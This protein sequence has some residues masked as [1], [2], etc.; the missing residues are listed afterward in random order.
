M[1]GNFVRDVA[2]KVKVYNVTA[3]GTY[4]LSVPA[5][6]LGHAYDDIMDRRRR[7]FA[8][9]IQH[10]GTAGIDGS[11]TSV[12]VAALPGFP[13]SMIQLSVLDNTWIAV[14][15][16]EISPVGSSQVQFSLPK[17]LVVL[18]GS[19][20]VRLS[21]PIP[22]HCVFPYF[23]ITDNETGDGYLVPAGVLS[24]PKDAGSAGNSRPGF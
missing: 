9:G 17:N 20:R 8:S 3:D 14:W 12:G 7:Y 10:W 16:K 22:R 1:I 24:T 11:R 19:L 2:I 13:G 18:D 5:F 15:T 4:G 6:P 21:D 23:T